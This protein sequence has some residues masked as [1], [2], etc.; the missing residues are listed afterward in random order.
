M[1]LKHSANR[2][3]VSDFVSGV[4]YLN[5]SAAEFGAGLTAGEVKIPV[6]DG[7]IPAYRAVPAGATNAPTILV[8]Q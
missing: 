1:R 7:T 5:L 2:A 8:V 3:V 6:A 4:D